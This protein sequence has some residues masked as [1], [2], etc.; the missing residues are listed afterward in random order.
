[1]RAVSALRGI[2]TS[3]VRSLLS[4]VGL[5]GF[6]TSRPGGSTLSVEEVEELMLGDIEDLRIAGGG[7]VTVKV[8]ALDTIS[9]PHRA[10]VKRFDNGEVLVVSI[11]DLAPHAGG[12]EEGLAGQEGTKPALQ[13]G[14][15][16]P[17]PNAALPFGFRGSLLPV[18]LL[19]RFLGYSEAAEQ[20]PDLEASLPASSSGGDGSGVM[21]SSRG[22]S[23]W[24]LKVMRR[25]WNSTLEDF[26]EKGP[27]GVAR[28]AALDAADLVRG[29][30]GGAWRIFR[31]AARQTVLAPTEGPPSAVL[32]FALPSA[33]A[34]EVRLE[35]PPPEEVSQKPRVVASKPLPGDSNAEIEPVA[36]LGGGLSV[37]K[38][39]A[40]CAG[41]CDSLRSV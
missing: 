9:V 33:E 13:A 21:P 3:S 28:D 16:S 29:A 27:K 7:L 26:S 37:L 24:F 4:H 19:G 36:E 34:E 14:M 12:E 5:S 17:L 20:R 41:S 11:H 2:A 6:A 22:A 40:T 1:M 15:L 32:D 10:R 25:E 31:K 18:G 38:G 23:V 35:E 39:P 8:L 30:L